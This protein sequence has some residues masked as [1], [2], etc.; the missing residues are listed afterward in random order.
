M[1]EMSIVADLSWNGRVEGGFRIIEEGIAECD[2]ADIGLIT[3]T[4]FEF[5]ILTSSAD[6]NFPFL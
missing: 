2:E 1:T 5:G 3:P 4:S 6:W